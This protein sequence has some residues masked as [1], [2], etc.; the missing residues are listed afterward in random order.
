MHEGVEIPRP[1][2]EKQVKSDHAENLAK[3]KADGQ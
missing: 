2:F 3:P 1:D